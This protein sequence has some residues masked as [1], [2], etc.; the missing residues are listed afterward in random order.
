MTSILPSLLPVAALITLGFF[1]G[2]LGFISPDFASGLKRLVAS[3]SLPV[4]L[5]T[6]F[7]RLSLTAEFF[8]LA[9]VVFAS[10]AL[11]GLAGRSFAVLGGL[12]RPSTTM[13]FQGFEAGMLGYA[14]F[15]SFYGS[16]AIPS[17][18]TADLGQV[19]YVFTALMAQLLFSEAARA[20]RPADLLVRLASSPVII[21]IVAG[22][23]SSALV[24]HA[25]GLPWAQG[26]FLSPTLSVIGSLTT[27]LVCLV[28]GY[29]LVDAFG[30]PARSS[31]ASA[32]LAGVSVV[33]VVVGRV[34]AT[35]LLGSAVAFLV[36]PALGFPRIQS[37]AVLSLFL[38]PPP[39]VIPVF[40]T[41]Q[42]DAAFVS[43]VLSLHT[44]VSLF[45]VF[46][47]ALFLGGAG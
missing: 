33:A 36:V 38:L 9:A 42:G 15:S 24:P 31:G 34:V 29:G 43:S 14:L 23:V 28:V 12:P 1:L 7:S 39:F 4:L 18:A 17:F 2:R 21:A 47:V 13:L 10:C 40:R 16:G 45:A 5:F 41:H 30:P 26:G 19:L 27:P 37:A 35:G 11:L 32:P 46:A 8:I 20:P 3:V 25:I 22:L 6:A 44:L